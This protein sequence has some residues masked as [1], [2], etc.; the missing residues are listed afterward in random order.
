MPIYI[1]FLYQLMSQP[2][3]P[4]ILCDHFGVLQWAHAVINILLRTLVFSSV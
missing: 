3:F 2:A 4:E 1:P